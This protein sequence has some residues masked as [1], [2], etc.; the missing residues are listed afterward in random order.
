MGRNPLIIIIPCHRVIGS[1]T[2]LTGFGG[3]LPR[4]QALLA[5]EGNL[6]VSRSP[7][8][9]RVCDE[10]GRTA[11]VAPGVAWPDGFGIVEDDGRDARPPDR[12]AYWAAMLGRMPM[13]SDT[14]CTAFSA[15]WR[16][17]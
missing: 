1:D 9:R 11:L 16:S 14:C 3:G 4:K 2:S 5:H 10:A 8:A 13:R 6:Y 15:L 7:R 12:R 17:G